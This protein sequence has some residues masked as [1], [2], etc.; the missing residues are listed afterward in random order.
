[1]SR[2]GTSPCCAASTPVR[3]GWQ[4]A[5]TWS[6]KAVTVGQ[7]Q[8]CGFACVASSRRDHKLDVHFL[9]LY[10]IVN[11]QAAMPSLLRGLRTIAEETPTAKADTPP[12]REVRLALGRSHP[13]YE[14][15][16]EKLAPIYEEP[17]AW[18]VRVTNVRDFVRHI[19]P[20]LERR[21]VASILPG[22]S[23]ELIV[24]FYRGGLRLEFDQGR[25]A[26]AEPWRPPA[27]GDHAHAGCPADVLQQLLFGYRS[28]AEL[29]AIYPDVWA[30]EEAARLID[31][32]F[33]KQPSTV[34][35]HGYI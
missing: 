24:D 15:V 28:L 4:G 23:G 8:R 10:P 6:S 25:L 3:Q 2:P 35:M 22:Y 27:Y 14:V 5:C 19:G 20:M 7:R 16:S 13:A 26:A 9:Q 29:R 32:L 31:I 30:G 33:P 34:W 11:W 17:Y 18:Y 12:L 1:M 21:L